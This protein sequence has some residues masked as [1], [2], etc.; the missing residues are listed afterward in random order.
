MLTN[1]RDIKR[2]LEQAG[3]TLERVAGSH[4]I[5]KHPATRETVILPHPKK[6]WAEA[7][8]APYNKQARWKPD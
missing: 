5:F 3:W 2:R 4:H 6:D 8:S 7:L 1:S